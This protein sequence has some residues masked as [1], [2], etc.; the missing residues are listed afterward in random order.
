MRA[1]EPIGVIVVDSL[2]LRNFRAFQSVKLKFS[3]LNIFVGP[4]NAGKSS[5]VSALNLIAQNAKNGRQ[6]SGLTL[7][8]AYTDLGTYYDVVNGHKASKNIGIK[9]AI[10]NFTYD[11]SFRFK[12]LRREIELY[13]SSMSDGT[14]YYSF[15]L[16]K[17]VKYQ[18]IKIPKI[19]KTLKIEERD[20]I[21]F[22]L[23]FYVPYELFM[24][25]EKQ[26]IDKNYRDE[27]RDL[28]WGGI[29][30]LRSDFYLFDSVGSFREQPQRTYL[31]SGEA[32]EEVGR[33]GENFAQ[34]MASSSSNRDNK[35]D[36]MMRRVVNWFKGA[37]IA[38][39]VI[40]K[41]LTNRHFE[42]CVEDR[43]GLSSNIVDVGFGCSQVL[44]VIIGGYKIAMKSSPERPGMYV[45]QEP[46]IHLHPS[47]AAHLGSFFCDLA[48]RNVQCFVETH[49][50]TLILRVARHIA[51]G[52]I[53]A[54]NVKIFWVGDTDGK[55]E[56]TE[57]KIEDD[58][59]FAMEW[60]GGFFPTRSA[61]TLELA[62][63][64]ANLP[65]RD[66]LDFNFDD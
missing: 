5:I 49:S 6:Q 57:L 52:N 19:R 65:S 27:I 16:I 34:I 54:E 24:D 26:N 59:S 32:P 28:F 55:R 15:N 64:A 2:E 1:L 60:P 17:N 36:A 66:V 23:S 31:Y 9:F 38:E 3:K 8:G 58:G 39:S 33:A 46:E 63:A 48:K 13:K 45:V 12:K 40:V 29:D 22:G 14:N 18:K 62:R 44:P 35:S 10:G 61:E 4:N 47:A 20:P 53:P 50:E 11:Y 30:S 51:N 21:F 7:N 41:G 56:V 42:L 43:L 37:G 25:F